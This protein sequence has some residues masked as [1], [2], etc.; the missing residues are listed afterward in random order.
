MAV[1]VPS[2]AA[3]FWPEYGNTDLLDEIEC[4]GPGKGESLAAHVLKTYGLSAASGSTNV[5]GSLY[6]MDIK[7][8]DAMAVINLSLLEHL[9]E[10]GGAVIYEAIV[11]EGGDIKFIEIGGSMAN[12][13]DIYYQVQTST[14]IES[15]LGV[16]VRGGKPM[17]TWRDTEW[18]PIWGNGDNESK[19]IYDSTRFMSSCLNPAVSTWAVIVFND[20]NLVTG[21]SS[22]KNGI[23]DLYELEEPYL[24]IV[25]YATHKH[26]PGYTKD[27]TISWANTA[28]VEV[29]VSD[30]D[31]ELGPNIGK[32]VDRPS[33]DSNASSYNAACWTADGQ[34]ID[35][36]LYG[37]EVEINEKLRFTDVRGMVVDKFQKVEEV[38]VMAQALSMVKSAPYNNDSG[39]LNE[40]PA[41]THKVLINIEN[42]NLQLFKLDPGEDYIVMY[43]TSEQDFVIPY[44]VFAKNTSDKDP[45]S[46]G[47][48]TPYVVGQGGKAGRY[49]QG[50]EG[51]GCILP[52]TGGRGFL[53]KQVIALVSINTPSIVIYDPEFN[54]VGSEGYSSRAIDIANNFEYLVRP[55]V[56]YEPPASIAFNGDILDQGVSERDNDPTT[57]QDFENTPLEEAM[58]IMSA[59][60]GME[61]TLPFLN[62]PDEDDEKLRTLSQ[63]LYDFMNNETGVE[64]T[65]VCGPNTSVE[66]GQVGPSGGVVNSITYSYNDSSSYTISVNEGSRMVKPLSG[67]GPSGATPKATESLNARGT[68][69]Q[70]LG[71]GIHFKVRI[72]GFGERVAICTCH[73]VIREGDIVSCSIYNN[74]VEV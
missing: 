21:T 32:P 7:Q 34:D 5:G 54:D 4:E 6:G 46:Y 41:T 8:M 26:A 59:G 36:V 56:M 52:A 25:G 74:P 1:S 55:I 12:L 19:I 65:Y 60:V 69:I 2:T 27:T 62:N 47:R 28:M 13:S 20:P 57:Q 42:P 73:D 70:A 39:A 9:A 35:P 29:L 30:N 16:L 37:V 53:V 17:P 51:V 10:V 15:C 61:I 50:T 49:D 63:S 11:D 24:N 68:V 38:Y 64:T 72:D 58:D 45:I 67:G 48:G 3:E 40:D 66:L 23:N 44:I 43:K 31:T 71:N 14:Y 18:L 22:Y 33:F